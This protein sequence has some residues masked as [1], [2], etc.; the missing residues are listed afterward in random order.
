M[1]S[2]FPSG[3]IVATQE[4]VVPKSIPIGSGINKVVEHAEI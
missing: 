1:A 3:P 2:G 4:N